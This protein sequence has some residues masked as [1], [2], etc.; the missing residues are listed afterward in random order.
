MKFAGVKDN[1]LDSSNNSFLSKTR[2][3]ILRFSLLVFW[4]IVLYNILFEKDALGFL[5][6]SNEI[7][8]GAIFVDNFIIFFKYLIGSTLSILF[9]IFMIKR[10]YKLLITNLS[11][12]DFEVKNQKDILWTIL[13]FFS[14]SVILQSINSDFAG[15]LGWILGQIVPVIILPF[16]YIVAPISIMIMFRIYP[17]KILLAIYKSIWQY[18]RKNDKSP[19]LNKKEK[20]VKMKKKSTI[21]SV[22][23]NK[24]SVV[25]D[26]IKSPTF[27]L[28]SS[29]LLSIPK[30]PQKQS[31]IQFQNNAK[32]LLRFFREFNIDGTIHSIKAGPVITVY[33]FEPS[34]GTKTSKVVALSADIAR[35][36][37]CQSIRMSVISGRNTIGVELP[38]LQRSIVSFRQ[39]VESKEFKTTEFTL[40]VV[41]GCDITGRASVVN[42][43]KMPHLL[44]AGRTGSG[45]SVFLRDLI[46]SL[47]YKC[48]PNDCKFILVDPKI[49]EFSDWEDIPHLLVPVVTKHQKVINSLKWAV[50]EMEKRY[51]LMKNF[52]VKDLSSFNNKILSAKASQKVLK[53]TVEI[54]EDNGDITKKEKILPLVKIPFI[55]IVIDELADLMVTSAKDVEP[56]LQRLAQMGRAA[57]I[58][59]VLATQRPS[60]NVITGV[61]KA[62]FPTRVSFQ[63]S[64]RVDSRTI[65]DSMGAE[66]LLDQ[67]D[68]LYM[69]AGRAFIRTHGA[70][71]SEIEAQRVAKFWKKQAPPEYNLDVFEDANPVGNA[72]SHNNNDGDIYQ[73]AVSLIKESKRASTS[74][75]QRKLRI[76]YGRAASMIDKMEEEGIITSPD[77][78]GRRT[79]VE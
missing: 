17:H 74:F 36:M 9:T 48:T 67:G 44:L 31:Q 42:L 66:S 58:H 25:K 40:P 19:S 71:V 45:K 60:V 47:L 35:S 10:S 8:K 14:I 52:G 64:S 1:F 49:I 21:K 75:L 46:I 54:A 56:S 38:N 43:L 33:E 51:R 37:K 73:Q 18:T 27:T 62:N 4:I 79:L 2:R 65:L 32:Q 20:M 13:T 55:V 24:I 70:F 30:L 69:P 22:P 11:W 50:R 5:I 76:G 61:I 53:Y 7:H 59:L 16:L 6:Y 39:M 12:I 23:K 77:Q 15:A 3:Y 72:T 41:L 28:P 78:M 29:E 68:M 63:V 26:K 57:G 34:P